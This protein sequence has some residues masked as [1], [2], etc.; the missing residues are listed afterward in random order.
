MRLVLV[1]MTQSIQRRPLGKCLSPK[2]VRDPRQVGKLGSKV[3]NWIA[4]R[5]FVSTV[6]PHATALSVPTL[7]LG[8]DPHT[9]TENRIVW[10]EESRT[11]EVYE[12]V[13]EVSWIPELGLW[14]RFLRTHRIVSGT[15]A[16]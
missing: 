14:R 11:N 7:P 15:K 2:V 6:N 8:T 3:G 16:E 4:L 13:Y 12:V 5:L 10:N 1:A 9:E